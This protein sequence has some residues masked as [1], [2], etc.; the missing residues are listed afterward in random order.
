MSAQTIQFRLPN[1]T[2]A[3]IWLRKAALVLTMMLSMAASLTAVMTYVS[4]GSTDDFTHLW[5]SAFSTAVMT[6]MPAGILLM[7]ALTKLANLWLAHLTSRMRSII[8]GLLMAL[9][10]ESGLALVTTLHHVGWQQPQLLLSSWVST[11]ISALPAAVVLMLLVS[12]TVKP[13][14]ERYLR[15]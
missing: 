1:N 10:M 7:A 6:I 13:R 5:F 11:L 3:S 8:V 12:L 15:S 2:Q 14:V 4:V 9:I